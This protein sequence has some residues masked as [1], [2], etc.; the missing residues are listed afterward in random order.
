MPGK[1]RK[2][3]FGVWIS[4]SSFSS[5]LLL[6]FCVIVTAISTFGCNRLI[7]NI[8]NIFV[9]INGHLLQINFNLS[10]F[11][12]NITIFDIIFDKSIFDVGE[13]QHNGCD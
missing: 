8:L 12:V 6:L 2:I 10:K 4:S 7:F 9:V 1:L 5:L 13:N 3:S 11:L